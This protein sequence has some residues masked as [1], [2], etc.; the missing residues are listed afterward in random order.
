MRTV[1]LHIEQNGEKE[2]V[3][4]EVDADP[5]CIMEVAIAESTEIPRHD[6]TYLSSTTLSELFLEVLDD[7]FEDADIP[8]PDDPE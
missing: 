4:V 3:D 7:G 2:P 1:R 6:L 8:K 5:F